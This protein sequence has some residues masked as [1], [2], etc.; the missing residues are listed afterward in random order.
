MPNKH[1]DK[2]DVLE[3][4]AAFVFDALLTHHPDYKTATFAIERKKR[5]SVKGSAHEIDVFVTTNPRTT[6]EGKFVVECKNWSEPVGNS[7]VIILARKVEA[8]AATGGFLVCHRL[9][10]DAEAE[11]KQHPRLKWIQCSEDFQSPLN[12]LE[13][14]DCD[15]DFWPCR[16]H[17]RKRTFRAA[18]PPEN[19]DFYS[20]QCMEYGKSVDL[21][22][23]VNKLLPGF[24]ESDR[25]E[26]KNLYRLG[27]CHFR[28]KSLELIF[29]PG[30]FT[31]N[32]WEAA[33]AIIELRYFARVT[34]PKIVS[35]FELSKHGRVVT[36]EPIVK[37]EDGQS[38]EISVVQVS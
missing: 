24:V 29:E 36:F 27:G 31:V 18:D 38:I 10:K 14:I 1:R 26:N 12:N 3:Q 8:V 11:L 4:V 35:R 32:G 7:E 13:L 2:G 9:T 37:S 21:F 22:R 30:E 16:I 15:Y 34:W 5:I 19:L 6:V 33:S 20:L 25:E 23:Y 28:M 17:F